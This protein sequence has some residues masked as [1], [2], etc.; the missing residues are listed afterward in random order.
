MKRFNFHSVVFELF[1]MTMVIVMI[2][3]TVMKLMMTYLC[4]F[5]CDVLTMM[6]DRTSSHI[7]HTATT[8]AHGYV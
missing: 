4:V 8:Y 5:S 3:T 1:L 6:D 2:T 7:L